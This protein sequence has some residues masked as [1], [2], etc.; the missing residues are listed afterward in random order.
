M[1]TGIA[2]W[3]GGSSASPPSPGSL[4]V[5]FQSIERAGQAVLQGSH[6]SSTTSGLFSG[7]H[8]T[9]YGWDVRRILFWY[10]VVLIF[11]VLGKLLAHDS[12]ACPVA[13]ASCVT[14]SSLAN[15]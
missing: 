2:Y 6:Q 7:L 8:G 13:N 9:V 12:D 10:L 11:G 15:L 14:H 4:D 1:T 5:A 3:F